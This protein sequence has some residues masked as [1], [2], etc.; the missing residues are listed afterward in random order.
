YLR[1]LLADTKAN[2]AKLQHAISLDSISGVA[3]DSAMA[4]LVGAAPAPA[5]DTFVAWVEH[6]A[7]SDEFQPIEG[8]YRALVGSGD[9]RLVRND[10]LRAALTGYLARIDAE[11]ARQRD[12]RMAVYQQVNALAHSFP[13][14]REIFVRRGT[15]SAPA[16][17][18]LR[19]DPDAASSLF[20][21]Q[22]ANANAVSELK[23]LR[24]TTDDVRRV[25]EADPGVAT[26][27][28]R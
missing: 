11:T 15:L 5:P 14:I 17:E 4:V 25:L 6:A 2:S 20:V 8:T 9:L 1:Q 24:T 10:S 18:R 3:A 19:H 26:T 21:W 22:A 27:S 7:T 12:I 13:F 16:L 23:V 28:R